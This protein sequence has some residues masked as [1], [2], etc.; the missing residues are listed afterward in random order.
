[1]TMRT[2]FAVVPT[3]AAT[4]HRLGVI[5]LRVLIALLSFCNKV[6]RCWPSRQ[7]ISERCGYSEQTVSRAT[8]RLA[9]CGWVTKIT[10]GRRGRAVTYLVVPPAMPG[11]ETI[12]GSGTMSGSD[13]SM[14]PG[15]DIE[16]RETVPESSTLTDQHQNRIGERTNTRAALMSAATATSAGS[17]TAKTPIPASFDI[18][19]ELRTWA[20]KHGY[21][22]LKQHLDY[23]RDVAIARGYRYADWD[24]AFRNA[25]RSNWAKLPGKAGTHPANRPTTLTERNQEAAQL[26]EIR[27]F[28]PEES[29][30]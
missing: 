24:A 3:T 13:T 12:S 8:A 27:I 5:D 15:S 29:S 23:F 22:G 4:D 25:I 28:G 19:A 21:D 6:G 20:A 14:V 30:K 16:V 9:R 10:A 1:M 18:S 7:A 17:G 26:A 11:S 2:P